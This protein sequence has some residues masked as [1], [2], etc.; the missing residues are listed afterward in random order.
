MADDILEGGVNPLESISERDLAV[1]R[2]VIRQEVRE[3][4]AEAVKDV[5]EDH[6]DLRAIVCGRADSDSGGLLARVQALETKATLAQ[7]LAGIALGSSLTAV[8]GL[9]VSLLT[10][11]VSF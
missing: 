5:K 2:L 1:L 11:R 9:V 3:G 7:W 4:C 6:E 10:H 8:V